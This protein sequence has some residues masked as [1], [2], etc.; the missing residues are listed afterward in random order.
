VKFTYC[1]TAIPIKS[2]EMF[3]GLVAFQNRDAAPSDGQWDSKD[4]YALV[5][6]EP[7]TRRIVT[8]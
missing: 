5:E 4:N 2:C 6:I 8:G 7:S 3:A 1:L